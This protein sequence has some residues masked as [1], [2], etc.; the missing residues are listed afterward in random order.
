MVSQLMGW[1]VQWAPGVS[2]LTSLCP[3]LG[4]QLGPGLSAHRY[5]T[6][7]VDLRVDSDNGSPSGAV[8]QPIL[9]TEH[10]HIPLGYP[11]FELHSGG[12]PISTG[13]FSGVAQA[14]GP[15]CSVDPWGRL[16]NI[17]P[18]GLGVHRQDMDP[19]TL[20]GGTS[21]VTGDTPSAS[22]HAVPSVTGSICTQAVYIAP[23]HGLPVSSL[24][25]RHSSLPTPLTVR[26]SPGLFLG[27]VSIDQGLCVG[28]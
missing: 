19:P 1:S 5:Y 12:T 25:H 7:P 8:L 6:P 2:S 20:S 11:S 21:T 24:N 17:P 10:L 18:A 4:V 27:A 16:T 28:E 22:W 13:S 14:E 26:H 3:L 23:L 15:E 9:H